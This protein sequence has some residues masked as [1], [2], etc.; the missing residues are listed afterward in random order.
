MQDLALSLAELHV[1]K[2]I[3]LSMPVQAPLDDISSLQDV[4]N[5]IHLGVIQ[6][7]C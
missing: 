5:T 2:K 1:I 7:A 4:K 6:K 3:P